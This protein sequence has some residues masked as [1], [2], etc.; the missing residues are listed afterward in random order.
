MKKLLLALSLIIP[1]IAAAQPI[2]GNKVEVTKSALPAGAATSALQGTTNTS[3]ATIATNTSSN[4]TAALQGTGNTSLATIATNTTGPKAVIATVGTAT[5]GNITT[6]AQTVAASVTG[7]SHISVSI[8]GTYTG[9]NVIFEYSDDGGTTWFTTTAARSDS[10]TVETTSGVL[11]SI[12]RAWDISIPSVTDFRVRSTAWTSGTA[13]IRLVP[14]TFPAVYAPSVSLAASTAVIG[15]TNQAQ[16]NG[17]TLL[18]G[19]GIAATGVQRMTIAS[20]NTSVA[21]AGQVLAGAAPP[22]G[23]TMV[24]VISNNLAG[25]IYAADANASINISTATT[26]Q[27]VALTAAQR[28]IITYVKAIAAGT[29]NFKLVYG[30]GTNCGTGTTDLT[31]ADP[32]TAQSG[33]SGGTGLGGILFVPAGNALC[34]TNS[35]AVGV[36]GFVSFTKAT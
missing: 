4:S 27:I 25:R 1:G 12:I 26:T 10:S 3:L 15:S 22:T 9:V 33:Y 6:S 28:I 21:P 29:T 2:S 24:G 30:T 11:A 36:T 7:Y 31:P 18:T 5:T 19:N 34:V 16:I 20:D 8:K 32:L 35:A 23:V 14:S 17:V 13:V